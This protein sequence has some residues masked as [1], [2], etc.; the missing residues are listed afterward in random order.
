MENGWASVV[1]HRKD[2]EDRSPIYDELLAA[3]ETYVSPILVH[4]ILVPI[5]II[6]FQ[7][8]EGKERHVHC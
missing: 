8:P 5:L 4:W 6:V 1:R 7:C 3:E 2:D